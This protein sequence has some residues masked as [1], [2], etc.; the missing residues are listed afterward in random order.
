MLHVAVCNN[1]LPVVQYAVQHGADVHAE[2][3]CVICVPAFREKCQVAARSLPGRAESLDRSM[4]DTM[5]CKGTETRLSMTQSEKATS[6]SPS[7]FW[8]TARATSSGRT[9]KSSVTLPKATKLSRSSCMPPRC[10]MLGL[11][12]IL[13]MLKFCFVAATHAW[14]PSSRKRR[15]VGGLR[16][17]SPQQKAMKSS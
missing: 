12:A 5:L 8:H 15:I 6:R 11:C 2:D 14:A 9:R 17:M 1:H 3:R 13:R 7:T 10:F 16:C 4:H